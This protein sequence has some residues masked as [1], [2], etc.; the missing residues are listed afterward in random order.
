M[1]LS[2]PTAFG[3]LPLVDD[4]GKL[5]ENFTAFSEPTEV[6]SVLRS[7]LTIERLPPFHGEV[8]RAVHVQVQTGDLEKGGVE[9]VG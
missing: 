4:E 9:G 2:I 3:E 1:G 5:V 6:Y 7:K 8:P